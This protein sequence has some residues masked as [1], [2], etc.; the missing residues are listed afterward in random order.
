MV[1]EGGVFV[2]GWN[3]HVW[4]STFIK[5]IPESSLLPSIL[6]GQSQ[7]IPIQEPESGPSPST[8][9]AG[10]LIFCV[11]AFRTVRNKSL[12]LTSYLPCGIL[13]Q[14]L[15]QAEI[16]HLSF[17]VWSYFVHHK[18]SYC[19]PS[20]ISEFLFNLLVHLSIHSFIHPFTNIFAITCWRDFLACA[21]IDLG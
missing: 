6:W 21:V 14:Q 17:F 2:R 13:L 4:V 1:L 19:P 3:L 10:T 12:L 9:S 15:Y 7:K 8:E 11:P 18:C 16:F 20:S 5:E